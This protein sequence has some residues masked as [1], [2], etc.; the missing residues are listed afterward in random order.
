MQFQTIYTLIY[1]LRMICFFLILKEIK[2]LII[3]R[4][5]LGSSEC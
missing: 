4:V 2:M 1:M 5:E 3:L